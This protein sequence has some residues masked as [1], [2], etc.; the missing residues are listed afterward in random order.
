ML[1]L[2]DGIPQDGDTLG[3]PA[4]PVELIEFADLQCPFCSAV[5]TVLLPPI[6]R[7]YVRTGRVKLVF[8]DLHFVGPDSERLAKVAEAMGMQDRL[9]QFVELAFEHQGKENSGYATDLYVTKLVTEIPGADVEAALARRDSPPV[10]DALE[11]ASR[12]A[13]QLNVRGTPAFFL[14]QP[15]QPPRELQLL[16]LAPST[17]ARE[18]AAAPSPAS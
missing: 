14:V 8:R 10:M 11:R 5:N 2:L 9:W 18:I 6:V 16:S 17:F 12:Q 7:D 1:A 13:D 4:A 15:G 3:N